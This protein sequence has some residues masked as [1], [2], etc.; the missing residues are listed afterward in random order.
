MKP[1]AWVILLLVLLS[2]GGFAVVSNRDMIIRKIA[3]AIAYAEGFH[4][5]GSVPNR[6][7]NP[8]D[9]TVDLTGKGIG[10]EGMY[11]R[12]AT[13]ADGWEAL[14][15]QVRLMFGGSR[16]YHA[17]MSLF[18]VSRR[19]TTTEQDAWARNVASHLNVSV[20]T[21]LSEIG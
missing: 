14:E 18:D 6:L 2:S 5:P 7:N 20:N 4:V 17:G 10:K 8:G 19:Y 15:K 13:A 1:S 21:K 16:I 11:I 9:L 3:Q 12:Y